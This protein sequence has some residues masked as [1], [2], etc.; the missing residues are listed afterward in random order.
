MGA[1]HMSA[2]MVNRAFKCLDASHLTVWLTILLKTCA[3]R[4]TKL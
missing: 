2:R 4:P 3:T 1:L